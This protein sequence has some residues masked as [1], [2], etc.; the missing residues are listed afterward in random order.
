MT[1]EQMIALMGQAFGE[2]L[3]KQMHTKA[4]ANV[5]TAG[6]LT[7]PG[8][9]FTVAGMEPDIITT[10]IQPAGLGT[11]LPVFQSN[12][13]DPRYGFITG[14]ANVAGS[15]ATNP[16]DDAPKGYMKGGTL[17]AQFGR[18]MRQT[19]T[20]EIDKLLHQQRGASTNLR[21]MGEMLGMGTGLAPSNMTQGQLLDLVVQAEMVGVGVQM[22]RKLATLLWQ[23]STA[24]NTAGGGYKEFPGLDNQIATGQVDAETNTAMA[25]ADSLIYDFNYNAVDGTVLDIIDYLSMQEFYLRDIAN[26]TGLSPVTHAVVM[27]PELWFELSA[28]WPCRYLTNRC[29][30]DS[31]TSPVV[32]NDNVNV[33]MRDGMRN[34][35]Y[36]DIN[37]KR[38]PVIT[39][40]GIFEHTNIN[41]AN[42]SAGSYASSIYFVPLRI[43]GNFP[44]TYWEHIDYRGVQ[45]QLGP[46]GAGARNAP[47]WTSDGRFLWVYRENGYCFDLQAKIEPRVVL[48]APHLAGKIQNVKYTP[49][50]HLRDSQPSSAYWVDGGVSLRS[51]SGVGS[52]VWT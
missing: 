32:I 46:L 27:R 49:L 6:M 20:I 26:R 36:I 45:A 15:E 47:F 3:A 21:L 16:C 33:T 39:D 11:A 34:G 52:H 24:N 5:S 50:T 19:E 51:F 40:D 1:Q 41:N 17:T 30:T 12:I 29:S 37:G 28:V 9:L 31:G 13:D 48:R 35:G 8:G 4:P 18:V 22:E 10:H 42:V 43:R 2:M 23:G 38:Y 7:Q 44:A 14:F 25:A